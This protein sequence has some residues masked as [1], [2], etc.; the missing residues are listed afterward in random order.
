MYG[1]RGKIG[2]LV[3]STNIPAEMDAH[4]LVPEGVTVTTGRVRFAGEEMAAP[5]SPKPRPYG[6]PIRPFTY[7]TDGFVSYSMAMVSFCASR[8]PS[9]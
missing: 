2:L 8:E 9:A 5:A 6:K 1:W 4:R 3:P 7:S